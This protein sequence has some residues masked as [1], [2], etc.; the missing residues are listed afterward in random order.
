MKK[1]IVTIFI[2]FILLIFSLN[3][4]NTYAGDLG[5]VISGGKSFVD[6]SKGDVGIDSTKLS[7]KITTRKNLQ[8]KKE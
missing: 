8:T 2:T 1:K 7:K 4:T 6:S 3:V 5:D